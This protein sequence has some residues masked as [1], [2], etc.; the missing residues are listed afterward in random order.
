[1]LQSAGVPYTYKAYLP[2]QIRRICRTLRQK[3]LIKKVYYTFHH[4]DSIYTFFK[5]EGVFRGQRPLNGSKATLWLIQTKHL[6]VVSTYPYSN[7]G[8]VSIILISTHRGW[9]KCDRDGLTNTRTPMIRRDGFRQRKDETEKLIG[10]FLFRLSQIDERM[11]I[12]WR[13]KNSA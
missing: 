8:S 10:V 4:D 2:E 1:M 9:D 7:S 6:F 3:C 5:S 11:C 13:K 12:F